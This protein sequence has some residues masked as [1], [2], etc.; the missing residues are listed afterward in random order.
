[1]ITF[2]HNKKRIRELE[3]E[4]NALRSFNFDLEQQLFESQQFERIA[5][6][7]LA[8]WVKKHDELLIKYKEEHGSIKTQGQANETAGPTGK[9]EF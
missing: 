2:F 9:E 6:D 7:K 5:S 8:V 3:D 4:N 1:M